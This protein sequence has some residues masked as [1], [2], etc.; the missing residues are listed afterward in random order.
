MIQKG[1]AIEYDNQK[2]T[3]TNV[4]IEWPWS[5]KTANKTKTMN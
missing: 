3:K 1:D 2:N 5:Q 4:K